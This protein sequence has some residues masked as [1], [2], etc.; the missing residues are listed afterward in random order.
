MDTIAA[1]DAEAYFDELLD[2]VERGERITITRQGKAVAVLAP[3][4]H[5][6]PEKVA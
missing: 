3:V 5:H 2:R 6:D 1:L 4:V